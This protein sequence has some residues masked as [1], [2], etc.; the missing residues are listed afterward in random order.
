MKIFKRIVCELAFAK[1]QKHRFLRCLQR[2]FLLYESDSVRYLA[3]N[4]MAVLLDLT[5]FPQK[6]LP[7]LLMEATKKLKR[8][9]KAYTPI[10]VFLYFKEITGELKPY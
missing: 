10:I 7:P 6:K 5:V 4:I 2:K 8:G 3:S 9:V 1:T